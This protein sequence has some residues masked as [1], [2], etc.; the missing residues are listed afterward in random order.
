MSG[1]YHSFYSHLGS[2][3]KNKKCCVRFADNDDVDAYGSSEKSV[4]VPKTLVH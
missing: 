1:K 3:E 2:W 4:I